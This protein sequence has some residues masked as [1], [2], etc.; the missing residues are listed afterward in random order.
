[1][2]PVGITGMAQTGMVRTGDL[3][4]DLTIGTELGATHIMVGDIQVTDGVILITDGDIQV[5][6]TQTIITPIIQAEEVL[7]ILTE[8]IVTE[9]IP[10]EIIHK[11][12]SILSAEITTVLISEE[13]Q[14]LR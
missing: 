6:A 12:K 2:I 4:L 5:M 7:P 3:V 1:M 11:I 13:T 14:V 9:T 8:Q 10:A